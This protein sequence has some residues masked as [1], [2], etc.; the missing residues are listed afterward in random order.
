MAISNVPVI[1]GP[2][3]GGVIYNL[4]L[5]QGF[6]QEPSKLTLSIVNKDGNYSTPSLNSSAQVSFQGFTFNGIIWSYNSKASADEKVLEVTLIDNSVILDR[7]YVLLWKRGLLGYFGETF[8][9][10]KDFDFSNESILVPNKFGD[11]NLPY[12]KFI[13]KRL[14][15]QSVSR[16]SRKLPWKKIGSLFLVG[17]EKFSDSE[18]DIPD[19]YYKFEDLR[20]AI[21]STVQGNY[22]NDANWKATHEGTLRE[23]LASWCADLGFDFYWDY[24]TNRLVFY[25]VSAGITRSL[26]NYSGPEVISKEISSS[27]EGTFRQYGLAYTAKPKSAVKTLSESLNVVT[28]YSVSPINI[29]YFAR[30]VGEMG[31]LTSSRDKWGGRSQDEF[32]EAA[33]L[34]YVSPALRDLYCFRKE[35]W[36]ALGYELNSDIRPNKKTI[37]D[38][39]RKSGYEEVINNLEQFDADGLPNYNIDFIN[40]DPT[41]SQKWQ[42]IEQ[43]ILSYYGRW[44]RIPDS[45]SSFF[46]CKSN[47]TIEI[48]ISVDPTAEKKEPNSEQ[49]AGKR[50]YDRGG[51]FSHDSASAQE[52]LGI[53]KLQKD[54]DNCAPI[55]IELK[56][57]GL[58]DNLVDSRILEKTNK[59]KINHIVIYPSSN[60]FVRGKLGFESSLTRSVNK[61]ETTWI[62]E[63]NANSGNG[64]KNCSQYDEFLEKGSCLSAEE[65]ARKQAILAAGGSVKDDE[66]QDDLVSGLNNKQAKACRITTKNGNIVLCAPSDSTLKVV[67]NYNYSINQISTLDVP[68][69]LWSVGSPGLA[70]DVAEIRIAN[71]N[72]TD[73]GEDNYQRKRET[74]LIRP[75]DVAA[76]S[77][78]NSIKYTFAG[79]PRGV[80]LSPSAGLTNLDVTISSEGFLSTA[81]YSTRSPKPSKQNNMVRYINSQFNRSSYNAS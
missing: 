72:I 70:L 55:H 29:S 63:R 57:S 7:H 8:S 36:Q 21:S 15:R 74:L 56:E 18:C 69:F 16:T 62:E 68:Q 13:E 77:R 43:T 40:H 54:I 34:G 33:F 27:M 37:I 64:I 28:T 61:L 67:T 78:N 59:D 73:P 1:S 38:F 14:G 31:S 20:S 75:K 23:V 65:I 10:K 11:E 81:T 25:D 45:N 26:P 17:T 50:I 30:K 6:S 9:I 41:L 35:H 44:Y 49:F 2:N 22:P 66:A 52:L 42:E 12:N 39:L 51:E 80:N 47:L 48:D 53:D 79:S 46:V 60:R 71:E 3:F 5:T 32:V 24:S 58:M 4:N 19:T 76:T